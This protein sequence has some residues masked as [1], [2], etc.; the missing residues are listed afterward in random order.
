MANQLLSAAFQYRPV[1]PISPSTMSPKGG[2]KFTSAARSKM[3]TTM[4]VSKSSRAGLLFSVARMHRK[5]RRGQYAKRIGAGASVYMAAVLEYLTAE[6]LEL[7]ADK[8][9]VHKKVR[10]NPRFIQLAIFSDAELNHLLS[11]VTI[12]A[13]GVEP[14]IHSVLLPKKKSLSSS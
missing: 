13:G 1:D 6:V 12:A 10:V 2:K 11:N 8:A 9:R 7:A 4:K 14:R 3:S 5:L